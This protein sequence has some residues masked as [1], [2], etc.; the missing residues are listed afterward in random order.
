MKVTFDN[1]LV[2]DVVIYDY[3][4]KKY[5]KVL[6]Y[7]QGQLYSISIPDDDKESVKSLIGTYATFDTE[8]SS[9]DGK[10]KFKLIK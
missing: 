8:M 6:V 9:F 2:C 4:E 7:Q 1:V 3:K 10:N 5:P